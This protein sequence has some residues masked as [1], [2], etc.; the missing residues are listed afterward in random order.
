MGNER[1]R[2]GPAAAPSDFS[3]TVDLFWLSTDPR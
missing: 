2:I 1:P 3:I